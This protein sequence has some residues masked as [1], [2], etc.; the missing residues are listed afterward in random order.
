MIGPV[1]N[2]TQSWWLKDQPAPVAPPS[3]PEQCDIAI[4]GAGMTGAS[5]AYWLSKN[6]GRSCILLDARGVAGG[7]TGR[8]GGHLWPRMNLQLESD[9]RTDL[10]EFIREHNVDCDLTEFGAADLEIRPVTSS[11]DVYDDCDNSDSSSSSDDT[12]GE[13]EYWDEETTAKR[14]GTDAFAMAEYN[15]HAAQFYPAKV[16]QAMLDASD[17]LTKVYAPVRVLKIIDDINGFGS[18]LE[19][20]FGSVMADQVVVASNAWTSE[21]LPELAKYIYPCRNQVLMTAPSKIPD[22]W[23]AGAFSVGAMTGSG[24]IEDEIYCI[25][26]PDG[27]ICVGGARYLETDAAIGNND[28]G[29]LSEVVGKRIREFMESSFP[30]LAPLVVEAEWTGII[31][32]TTDR[33][34]IVGRIPLRKNVLVAAGYNGSGMSMCFGVG[35]YI[36]NMLATTNVDEDEFPRHIRILSPARFLDK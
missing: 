22:S 29:S 1:I 20:D 7:A 12:W 27:R 14:F 4:I 11:V 6:H 16:T 32:L 19:T 21:L 26:R 35:K 15:K 36:A 3:L 31:A 30:N 34:P 25:R 24:D 5:I 10:L 2:P 8:N 13:I 18:I 9:T 33:K 17:P 23:G 28:D